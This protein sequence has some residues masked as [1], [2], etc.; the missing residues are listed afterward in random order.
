MHDLVHDLAR[1]VMLDEVLDASKQCNMVGS[2]FQFALLNDCTKS[3]KSFTQYPTA[4][5][6]LRFYGTDKTVL[7]DVSFSSAKYLCVL[8]LSWCSIRK[9][10]DSIGDLKHLRYLNAP[11]VKHRAI[12]NCITKL[13]KLIYLS[14][15]GSSLILALPESIG[16]MEGLMYLD[17]SSCLSLEKLP[18]SFGMLTKLVHLD[19]SYCCH[20]T[21]VSKSLESL[22]NL[23]YLNL[24]SC[25][26][27]GELPDHLGSLLQL[28]NLN[29]SYSSYVEGRLNIKA[30]VALTKLEE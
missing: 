2:R 29:L 19:L 11:R 9:L 26:S 1:S 14:L 24:S 16:D 13:R 22:T 23:E 3:L 25:W 18:V 27:I 21:G 17:L 4:I 5:R 20:I 28:R 7:H 12:P 15:R 30:L 8:D 6:A 10:P